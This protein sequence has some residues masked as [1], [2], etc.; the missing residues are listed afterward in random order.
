[1]SCST[2]PGLFEKTYECSHLSRYESMNGSKP[3]S[4]NVRHIPSK[5]AMMRAKRLSG[6]RSA[7]VE[8]VRRL[9]S[10]MSS[11]SEVVGFGTVVL[12][13]HPERTQV[14]GGSRGLRRWASL[15]DD[16]SE[17]STRVARIHQD[18][19]DLFEPLQTTRA[20][21]AI[22]LARLGVDVVR[23]LEPQSQISVARLAPDRFDDGQPEKVL[24][25]DD[26][27]REFCRKTQDEGELEAARWRDPGVAPSTSAS[28]LMRSYGYE[29]GRNFVEKLGVPIV[30]C[31]SAR[32]S[33]SPGRD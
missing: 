5:R 19:S 18:S 28:D 26:P 27:G 32:A 17:I 21:S 2:V 22:T 23:P 11:F 1:M 31:T 4:R 24:N 30:C 7:S 14:S 33:T 13:P 29:S 6:C 3:R 25:E 10:V 12:M 8:P 20:G 9:C 16:Q 15:T